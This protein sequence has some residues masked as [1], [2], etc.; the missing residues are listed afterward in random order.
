MIKRS[1]VASLLKY[2]KFPAVALLGPRQSGKTT[3]AKSVFSKHKFFSFEDE[4][5]R[6]FA[7]EDPKR[8]LSLHENE[9]GLILDEF[10]HVPQIL[11]YIQVEIDAKKRPGYFILTGSQNF[12][13][14][15]A[16]TQSLAG[17]VGIIN[18]FPLSM[19]ELE[20]NNLLSRDVDDV[21]FTGGYPRIYHENIPPELLY[22]SY[23]QSYIE[24][25]VRQLLNVG[26][27]ALFQKFVQLCAGRIGQLLNLEALGNECG[28]TSKTAKKW[29]TVLEASYIVFQLRPHHK[30]FN[31]RV[32]KTPKLY[33]YDTGLACSLLRITSKEM[34]AF[35]PLRAQLFECLIIADLYKQYSNLGMRSPLYFWR[36]KNGSHEV[37]CIIDQGIRLVPVEIK[38]GQ[39][40]ATDY[41]RGLL[42]WS[43]I[44]QTDSADGY[45]VYGGEFEQTRS[46]GHVMSWQAAAHLV[47]RIEPHVSK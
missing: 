28:I 15:Q 24:R 41:F 7:L 30:N 22:P 20:T 25:D 1:L 47:R 18:L 43:N 19:E 37:D 36:D 14:N 42:Y 33:F 34:L 45:I 4:T 2:A 32:T 17:R 35:H 39:T 8:F 10:Q 3:L 29:I 6:T 11:S 44:A 21:I 26:D 5:L 40:I 27:L 23:T 13:M 38:S 9:H 46:A 31:K 12:L 16:I